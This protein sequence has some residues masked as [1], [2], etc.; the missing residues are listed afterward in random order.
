MSSSRPTMAGIL[1]GRLPYGRVLG[2][3]GFVGSGASRG[4][5]A[6]VADRAHNLSSGVQK[7]RPISGVVLLRGRAAPVQ[8]APLRV[9]LV[10]VQPAHLTRLHGQPAK[11]VPLPTADT[12]DRPTGQVLWERSLVL[13]F[14]VFVRLGDRN[15]TVEGVS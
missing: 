10:R 11:H 4:L 6:A 13:E 9:G 3:K 2:H 15:T 7:V 8:P 1:A 5:E 14:H 12:R